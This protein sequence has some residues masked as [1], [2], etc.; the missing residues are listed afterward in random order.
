[1]TASATR[2]A[3][4]KVRAKALDM[5]AELMQAPVDALDIVDGEVVRTDRA[6]GPSMTLGADRGGAAAAL[7]DARRPRAR[8]CRPRA[9]STPITRSTPTATISPW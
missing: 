9:G 1:M 6:G 7:E 4:L 5:A 3:A 8:A 2:E